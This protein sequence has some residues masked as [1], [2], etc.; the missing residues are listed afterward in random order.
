[1]SPKKLETSCNRV[2]FQS[3]LVYQ[4]ANSTN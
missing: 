4:V 2:S 1:M 3:P